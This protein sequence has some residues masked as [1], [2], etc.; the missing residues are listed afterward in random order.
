CLDP[1]DLARLQQ[2][3]AGEQSAPSGI[4]RIALHAAA[5]E[6]VL[7][8][9]APADV[10]GFTGQADYVEGIHDRGGVGDLLGGGCLEPSEAVHRDDLDA[11][12]CQMVCVSGR[13]RDWAG[14]SCSSKETYRY[15]R[16]EALTLDLDLDLGADAGFGLVGVPAGTGA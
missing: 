16:Q 8:D 11:R 4:E 14:W 13:V 5:T 9:A 2:P 6:D 3:S 1:L 15:G 7:L 10:Q 12:G